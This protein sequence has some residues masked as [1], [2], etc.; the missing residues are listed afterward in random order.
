MKWDQHNPEGR[1]TP[2]VSDGWM[3]QFLRRGAEQQ[4]GMLDQLLARLHRDLEKLPAD[5][6][7][8]KDF[9]RV[10]RLYQD[11]YKH[12]A[13][14]E[15]DTAKLRLLAERAHARAPM[16][17][18]EFAAQI[19]ALGRQAVS[20]LSVEELEAELARKRALPAPAA[21]IAHDVTR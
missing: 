8:G 3:R 10:A 12:L 19:E 21:G 2:R 14:L 4:A 1:G 17:D 15:L 13:Q 18:E 20:A 5:Q 7:P 6:L 9:V 11:G 16:T